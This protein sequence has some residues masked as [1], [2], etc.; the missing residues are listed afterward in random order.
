MGTSDETIESIADA[1]A[2]LKAPPADLLTESEQAAGCVILG[3][4][5]DE[6]ITPVPEDAFVRYWW[7]IRRPLGLSTLHSN[8]KTQLKLL[9]GR[10]LASE[11][12]LDSSL[13]VYLDLRLNTNPQG[14]ARDDVFPDVAVYPAPMPGV[15]GS[16]PS[17]D[18][19][20]LVIEILSEA[21]ETKDKGIKRNKYQRLGVLHYWVLAQSEDPTE[22]LGGSSFLELQEGSYVDVS[23]DFRAA[24][25]LRCDAIAALDLDPADVWVLE[26]ERSVERQWLREAQRADAERERANTERER[27]NALAKELRVLKQT[28]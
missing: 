3:P 9:I 13:R 2:L 4:Y 1:V 14:R 5:I 8:M 16:A 18:V 19:P 23:E 10:H 7:I 22:G 11:S 20:L 15:V 6:E 26:S 25:H 21:T 28:K 24:G 17:G 12:T 27:A